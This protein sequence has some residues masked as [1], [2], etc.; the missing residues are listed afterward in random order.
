MSFTIDQMTRPSYWHD[1]AQALLLL[2]GLIFAFYS[3]CVVLSVIKKMKKSNSTPQFNV[4]VSMFVTMS[5]L[6]FSS[7]IVTI[8]DIREYYKMSLK[9]SALFASGT[10]V[11]DLLSMAGPIIDMNN[12]AHRA[13]Y[14][15][16]IYCF[17]YALISLALMINRGFPKKNGGT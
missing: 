3:I 7:I 11:P 12:A 1:K 14:L 2:A 6:T 17:S 9:Q 10:K 15:A 13:F 4:S 8:I 16:V 5:L